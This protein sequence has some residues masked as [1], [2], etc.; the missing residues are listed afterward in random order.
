MLLT[1]PYQIINFVL[2]PAPAG[3]GW[4][5]ANN[6]AG[7]GVPGGYGQAPAGPGG[8]GRGQPTPTVGWNQQNNPNIG[9]S[10]AGYP[11]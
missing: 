6:F 11:A 7:P 5:Q 2:G 10:F 8:Y 9:N 3:R 4:E 1:P